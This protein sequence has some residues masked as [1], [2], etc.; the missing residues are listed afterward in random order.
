[1]LMTMVIFMFCRCKSDTNSENDNICVAE[2]AAPSLAEVESDIFTVY[3]VKLFPGMRGK[4]FLNLSIQR[5]I[6]IFFLE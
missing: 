5:M 6:Y 2:M 3:S 4:T 1:M